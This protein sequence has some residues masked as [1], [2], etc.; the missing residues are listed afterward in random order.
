MSG[1]KAP[2]DV[3]EALHT[4]FRGDMKI[5][6]VA[7]DVIDRIA[8]TPDLL[9]LSGRPSRSA[10]D[11]PHNGRSSAS[12]AASHN[13]DPEIVPTPGFLLVPAGVTPD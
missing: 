5:A 3:R 2:K 6:A 13:P 9:Q 7:L 10:R 12:A 11:R 4:T 8:L 1:G